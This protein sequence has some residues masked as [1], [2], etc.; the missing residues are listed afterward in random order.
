MINEKEIGVSRMAA[1]PKTSK[2]NVQKYWEVANLRLHFNSKTDM[3][4]DDK[5]AAK[6]H[7][8][9][10]VSGSLVTDMQTDLITLG[11]LSGS[12]DGYFGSKSKRAVLRFQRH[13]K[14][15]YRMLKGGTAD[16]V[17]SATYNGAT[18]GICDQNTAKEIHLWISKNWVI[19]IGRFSLT[20]ISGGKLRSDAA[21]V[22]HSLR[23]Q[24]KAKGGTIDGPYG[25]TTRSIGFRKRTGGNS[26]YSMHYTG[27]ALDLSQVL[28]GG[29]NQ[30]YYAV[31]EIISGK[32]YFRIYCKTDKQD[33]TQGKKITKNM[34]LKQYSFYTKSEIAMPEAYYLDITTILEQN[35][36]S[37]IKAHSN[38]KTNSKGTEWW[39]Y[40][41]DKDI[42]PTFQDEM[43]L[44]GYT[45]ET[46]RKHGW[47]TAAKL[48]HT[49]G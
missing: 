32:V 28:A 29:K 44:I 43:E 11:Y 42:Q 9:V 39:H 4:L 34:K 48:D 19:P 10:T 47:N 2:S 40:Y 16:D 1:I 18:N 49:P 33:G 38:W 6:Y 37:R 24:I 13:A 21:A 25:D 26:L 17:K 22:W 14:R 45:E 8:K 15:L 27:R 12:A 30:R 46:L 31:K 36:F 41:Y 23:V 20:P 3:S 5:G 7:K 35:N